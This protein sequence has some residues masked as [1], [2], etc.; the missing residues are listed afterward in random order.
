MFRVTSG[1]NSSLHQSF[2][3]Y[4]GSE[5]GYC[6]LSSLACTNAPTIVSVLFPPYVHTYKSPMPAVQELRH[7]N[8]TTM[9]A[10]ISFVSTIKDAMPCGPMFSRLARIVT[11]VLFDSRL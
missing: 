4:V 10:S 9:G 7:I 1:V 3:F 2:S 6:R 5:P 8:Q 11:C